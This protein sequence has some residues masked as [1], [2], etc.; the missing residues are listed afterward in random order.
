MDVETT[1]DPP[2]IP[3]TADLTLDAVPLPATGDTPLSY[4][5][6]DPLPPIAEETRQ[7]AMTAFLAAPRL[8]DPARLRVGDISILLFLLLDTS[9]R[10][11]SLSRSTPCITTTKAE[12]IW[13]SWSSHMEHDGTLAPLGSSPRDFFMRVL[14][15]STSNAGE[16][17]EVANLLR[18][19]VT[20]TIK[21]STLRAH[22][23]GAPHN[24]P[25]PQSSSK[26]GRG[27][28]G[29]TEDT[30][31]Y[32]VPPQTC[33]P[34]VEDLTPRRDPLVPIDT[35]TQHISPLQIREEAR[36]AFLT[37]PMLPEL[38]QL[39]L[40]HISP[41]LA[42]LVEGEWGEIVTRLLATSVPEKTASAIWNTWKQYLSH[43]P[44]TRRGRRR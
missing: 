11:F 4:P 40:N 32:L 2:V 31:T 28:A 38:E 9:T 23:M 44:P 5:P 39:E 30:G 29:D 33:A 21:E 12:G 3:T 16:Q 43:P 36:T 13:G 35:N 42:L 24:E 19:Y 41:L 15:N 6:L 25:M 22:T 37:H 18:L 8:R 26:R 1:A 14:I 17:T 27:E 10:L 20:N 34:I 7:T